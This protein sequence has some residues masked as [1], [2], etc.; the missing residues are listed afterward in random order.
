[1]AYK[2]FFSQSDAEE[3]HDIIKDDVSMNETI[4]LFMY[5]L[6]EESEIILEIEE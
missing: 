6:L 3:L 4:K 5:M 2:I 1:M